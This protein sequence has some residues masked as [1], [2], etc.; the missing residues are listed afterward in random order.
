MDRPVDIDALVARH[1]ARTVDAGGRV[2]GYREAG[3][4]SEN[5]PAIVLLHGIGSGSASWTHQL[6]GLADRFRVVAWDA[7]GYGAST[8]LASAAPSASEY[9]A[10]LAAF[11]DGLRI[12]RCVLVGHSLGALIAAAFAAAHPARV[13]SL[14]LLNPARGYR[15]AAPEVRQQ[16]LDDRLAEM[17]RL[18]PAAHARARV[19]FQVGP[20]ASEAARA[21][22]VWNGARLHPAGYAQA[23]HMLAGGDVAEDAARYAGPVVVACGTEDRITPEPGCREVARAF[24]HAAY[25]SLAGVG[26]ASYIEDPAAANALLAALAA[27]ALQP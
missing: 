8:P 7:P 22:L 24:A 15:N 27:P 23:A 2:V 12:E 13:A 4:G 18:G 1:P 16:K 26:H 19:A 14:V 21:L 9:A 11:L 6:D 20:S 5:A 17:E 25:R 3:A 10:A